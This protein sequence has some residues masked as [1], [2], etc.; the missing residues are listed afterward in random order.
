MNP[1][2]NKKKPAVEIKQATPTTEIVE[3]GQ[4]H[5]I[6]EQQKIMRAIQEQSQNPFQAIAQQPISSDMVEKMTSNEEVPKAIRDKFWF[7]FHKDNVLT[8][9]D[10]NRK[11][12]KM[13]NFDIA[14]IDFLN[15]IPYYDYNFE[16]E[17]MFNIVRNTFETKLDRALGTQDAN[18]K[19][20]RV[21]LQSQLSENRLIQESNQ[22]RIKESFF[23]RL[24]GRRQ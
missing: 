18:R 4:Q 16:L 6:V 21:M 1:L 3:Q 23:K 10:E 15:R 8:F 24:L 14:K 9:L 11:A 20:E 5:D 7:V 22:S 13:L 2:F 19:N 12:S 17:E